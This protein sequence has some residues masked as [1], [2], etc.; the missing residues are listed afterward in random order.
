MRKFI[1]KINIQLSPKKDDKTRRQK[2]QFCW[3]LGDFCYKKFHIRRPEQISKAM[4]YSLYEYPDLTHR[5]L[6]TMLNKYYA[7][8]YMLKLIKPEMVVPKPTQK[9]VDARAKCEH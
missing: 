8:A 7:F 2:L 1:N 3:G 4:I 6:A 9:N 5:T